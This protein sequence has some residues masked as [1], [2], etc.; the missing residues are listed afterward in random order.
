MA[1]RN[2]FLPKFTTLRRNIKASVA[3]KGEETTLEYQDCKDCPHG[4]AGKL[5]FH[6]NMKQKYD[7]EYDTNM[8]LGARIWVLSPKL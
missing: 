3:K 8:T 1:G 5:C 2:W 4:Q 6:K 7:Q